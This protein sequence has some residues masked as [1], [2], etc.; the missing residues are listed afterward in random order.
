M[1]PW[2]W[3]LASVQAPAALGLAPCLLMGVKAQMVARLARPVA[4]MGTVLVDL[5]TKMPC[6]AADWPER[7]RHSGLGED[8]RALCPGRHFRLK[9]Q[10]YLLHA[11]CRR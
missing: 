1:M 7:S 9:D 2:S 3:L 10:R 8:Y 4:S 5:T 6:L 11:A